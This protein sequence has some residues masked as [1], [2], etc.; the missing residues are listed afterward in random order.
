MPPVNGNLTSVGNI[1]S[2]QAFWVK[3]SGLSPALVAKE[4]NKST[5]TSVEYYRKAPTQVVNAFTVALNSGKKR[6]EAVIAIRKDATNAYDFN[7]DGHKKTNSY[8]PNGKGVYTL[9]TLSE[10]GVSLAYNFIDKVKCGT[11]LPL[12]ILNADNGTYTIDFKYLESLEPDV[13]IE[14]HDNYLKES[15]KVTSELAYEFRVSDPESSAENRFAITLNKKAPKIKAENGR[16][17]AEEVEGPYQWY[18]EG[19]AIANATGEE[20]IAARAGNYEVASMA[21]GC[22]NKSTAY[23]NSQVIEEKIQVWPNPTSGKITYTYRFEAETINVRVIS[24]SGKTMMQQK[25]SN[26][27][28]KELSLDLTSLPA[29]LYI[30]ELSDPAYAEIF[31]V[32]RK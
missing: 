20:L 14:L 11:T 16:L 12:R 5:D 24:A 17:M 32:I 18:Y 23:F 19:Q 8:G 2:G 29:G 31:R 27:P 15:V 28:G 10:D 30:I 26:Y 3:A 25:H 7:Y 4:E 9:S 21:N 1:A 13:Y 22:A 6:D